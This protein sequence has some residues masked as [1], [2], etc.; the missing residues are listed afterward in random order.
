MWPVSNRLATRQPSLDVAPTT[1]ATFSQP[2]NG[3]EL[4]DFK[5][6]KSNIPIQVYF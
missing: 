1:L 4:M 2:G 3:G 6:K 5:I